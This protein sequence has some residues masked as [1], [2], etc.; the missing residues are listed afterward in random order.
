M[1]PTNP[2]DLPGVHLKLDRA[3]RHIETLRTEVDAFKRRDPAPWDFTSEQRAGSGNTVE[4]LLYAV[5]RE[6]PPPEWVLIIGDAIQNM[7]AA[8]ITSSTSCRRERGDVAA[9]PRSRSSTTSASSRLT[10]S[11]KSKRSRAMSGS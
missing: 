9:E 8:S 4:H 3:G 1:A 5:I 7:R 6:P 11:L 10:A 2:R